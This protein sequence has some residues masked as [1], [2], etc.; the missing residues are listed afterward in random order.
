MRVPR[1]IWVFVCILLAASFAFASKIRVDYDHSANFGKYRTFTLVE[2]PEMENP[3]MA[4]RIVKSVTNQLLAKGLEPAGAGADLHVSVTSSTEQIPVYNTFYD[5]WGPGWGW[6]WGGSGWAT[7]YVD[8][9]LQST[10]VVN[11]V[12][13]ETGKTVWHGMA[14][15]S[16]SSKPEKA[17]RKTAER[18]SEMFEKYPY[19]S[20]PISD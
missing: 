4:D 6:G 5:S 7:T 15:G 18:I 12:D 8:T 10:T 16:V 17:S 2:I 9:Y 20:R 14:T 3:I 11:L 19:V 1:T 13:S